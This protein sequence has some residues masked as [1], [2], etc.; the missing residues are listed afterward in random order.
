LPGNCNFS[1][2]DVKAGLAK[3]KN[4]KSIGPD[5]LPGTFLYNLKSFLCISLFQIF[6]HSLDEG[7]FPSIWKLSL[8]SSIFKSGDKS[9]VRNYRPISILSHIAKLFESLVL[10]NI[11]PSLNA[12]LID[13]QYG[14]RPW[15]SAATNLTIF[16]NF[17]LDAFYNKS[18]VDVIFTDFAKAFDRVDHN[19][20][21]E[22]LYKSG[23]GE[24]LLYWFKSYLS[25]RFQFVKIYGCKFEVLP[26]T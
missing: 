11:Q 21:S 17:V 23:F 15:R 9:N 24:P 19:F 1:V 26:I 22:F 25:G 3:L 7:I 8:I 12:I 2:A 16:S 20:L 13:E 18:Q 4:V 10:L 6:R 5:G 14:F